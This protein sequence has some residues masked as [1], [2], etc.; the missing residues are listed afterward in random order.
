MDS[1]VIVVFVDAA[2]L[3][4]LKC[5]VHLN[6]IAY[7]LDNHS[8]SSLLPSSPSNKAII[9][10]ISNYTN[11]KDNNTAVK[12][13]VSDTYVFT[14][15]YVQPLTSSMKEKGWVLDNNQI[16]TNKTWTAKWNRGSAKKAQ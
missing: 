1:D 5:Y 9:N 13:L 8:P 16:L 10:A 7:I 6:V 14:Q 2:P 12:Q 11:N 3:D 15:T 4:I